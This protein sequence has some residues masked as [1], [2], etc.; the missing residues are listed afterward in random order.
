MP[1]WNLKMENKEYT[2][3]AEASSESIKGSEAH[4]GVSPLL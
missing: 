2:V 3:P 4:P 1:S